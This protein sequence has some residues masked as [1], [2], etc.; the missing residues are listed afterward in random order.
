VLVNN[1]GVANYGPAV[2]IPFE[3]VKQV[4]GKSRS[5]SCWFAVVVF[6]S[7]KLFP[8]KIQMFLGLSLC[9]KQL[10]LI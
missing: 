9:V 1:A 3:Q 8:V 7:T 10:R 5:V 4:F 6:L 2:E